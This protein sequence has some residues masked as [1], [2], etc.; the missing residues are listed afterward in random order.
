MEMQQQT[1]RDGA[2]DREFDAIHAVVTGGGSGIGAAIADRLA[3]AGAVLTLIGR[4]EERLQKQCE[5]LRTQFGAQAGYEVADLAQLA[6]IEPVYAAAIAKR[7]AVGLLVNNAGA[8]ETAPFLKTTQAVLDRMLDINLKQVV[9]CTQA[10]LPS[11]SKL[12]FGRIVNIS[13]VSGLRGQGYVSAYCISKHAVIGL[14]RSLAAEL[15]GTAITVNAVCPAYT[16]TD[17]VER[18]AASVASKTKQDVAEIKKGFAQR[19]P[20][21]RIVKP[22]EVADTVMWLCSKRSSAITGQAIEVG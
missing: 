7:G 4:N 19:N 11:M 16:E 17:L 3:A 2:V 1:A 12:P 8:V 18:V 21:G 14:T 5:R 20:T 6:Q 13:S 10:A 9:F 22:A 15:S